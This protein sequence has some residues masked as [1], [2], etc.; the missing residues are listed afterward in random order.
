MRKLFLISGLALLAVVS[1]RK[2]SIK[3]Y[4]GENDSVCFVSQMT[5]FSFRGV[6]EDKKT[7]LIPL[8]LIGNVADYDREVSV[9]VMDSEKN[10][11]VENKDFV[12][13][14][15]SVKAGATKGELEIEIN[16]LPV[17]Q[18]YLNVYLEIIPNVHFQAGYKEYMKTHVEWSESYVRP[19]NQNVWFLWYNYLAPCY[20]R[21]Y[22]EF[23]IQLF[24]D[25]IERAV[26]QPA[27]LETGENLVY[28]PVDM[29]YA[30][31][32]RLR[33]EVMDHDAQHPDQ[34]LRHSNDYEWYKST[35]VPVG[36]GIGYTGDLPP[37]ILETLE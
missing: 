15:A 27:Q 34:P 23:L 36:E 11:A 6:V 25:E 30:A 2:D 5:P 12:L 16:N 14:S 18:E 37:T 32:R 20:S 13:K 29:W 8:T 35:S 17:G 24:G 9:R 26:Y 33:Q 4:S 21:A 1:C 7:F 3:P 28:W 31:K 19:A 22:H 10:T